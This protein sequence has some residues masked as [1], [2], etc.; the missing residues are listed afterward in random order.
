MASLQ[1]KAC[2]REKPRFSEVQKIRDH[3]FRAF[4]LQEF[5]DVVVRQRG[6]L[7]EDL[8]HHTDL[9]LFHAGARQFVEFPDHGPEDPSVLAHIR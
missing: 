4:P 2:R 6:E 9:R 7:D 1:R 3:G 8:A 5:H